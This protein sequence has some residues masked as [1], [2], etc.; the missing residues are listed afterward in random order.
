MKQIAIVLLLLAV[1][2]R[3]AR[4]QTD[5]IAL[6]LSA[7]TGDYGTKD[8][9][10]FA[11][12]LR[13]GQLY[14]NTE[15]YGKIKMVN[16]KGNRF[17]LE[18]VKPEAFFEFNADNTGKV[19]S[20]V[21]KQ[22]GKFTWIKQ[23]DSSG[24]VSAN[25]KFAALTGTYR[26]DIDA[27]NIL[28]VS[29][30]NG[31]LQFAA[32]ELEPVTATAFRRYNEP[33]NN[34]LYEFVKDRSGKISKVILTKDSPEHYVKRDD[35]AALLQ[36]VSNRKNGFTRADTVRGM[37]TPLRTCYDVLFYGLDVTVEPD[38]RSVHGHN[39]IR[40]KTI[41]A[42]DSIQVDL[43]ANMKIDK[44]LFHGKPLS[45]SRKYHAVYVHFPDPLKPG[46]VEELDIY[47]A[48][49]PQLPDIDAMAGGFFWVHNQQGK[50][51]VES[52]CQ[53]AGASLWWPCKD[54]LSDEPDSMSIS[55][56]IPNNG[57]DEISNGRLLKKTALPNNYTRYDW[58]V[59]YPI[60]NYNVVVNIGDFMHFTDHYIR[61]NGDTL[62][63][64]YYCMPYNEN[65]AKLI[66]S[67]VKPM[68]QLFEKLFGEY[69]FSRDGFTVMEGFYPM[70]HQ[71]AVSIGYI[72][73]PFD[74]NKMDTTDIIRLMW[75]EVAHEWWGNNIT[76]KDIADMWIH[77]SFASYAELLAFENLKGK[78]AA[79]KYLS[80]QHP[81]NKEPIIGVYDVNHFHMGDMYTKG[82]LLLHTL[83][84]VINN[85]DL[86]FSILYGLQQDFRYQTVTT[87]DI[88][89]YINKKAKKDYTPFFDQ[90]LRY[91]AIPEL[92]LKFEKKD[93]GLV[94]QYRWQADVVAFDM[95]V[96]I[97]TTPGNMQF[98]YPTTQWQTINLAG[99][100]EKDVVADT[101]NFYIRV[102]TL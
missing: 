30:K 50:M 25:S 53:G 35:D 9:T 102:K 77:E 15:H 38:T 75:H 16:R 76:D 51:W 52:V 23:P 3:T 74:S 31:R 89:T 67:N 56:T 60:N 1:F 29:E 11:I 81:D 91:A 10:Q 100:N 21:I 54:H 58:Y 28:Q 46:N 59:S 47:Y 88:V 82:I 57:L 22:K 97:A 85:D 4:S 95:P 101:A 62:A 2:T 14:F 96:K 26:Q 55:I 79:R 70:E 63:L 36:H 33:A 45:Y 90:Y 39:I 24:S 6:P 94:V 8:S 66:F 43:Y 34:S 27:F 7:Y 98:I 18:H 78:E 92:Q 86:W 72:N 68:L 99:I 84:N 83:R 40:F 49:K 37:L 17:Q 61:S 65:N 87:E 42:A 41:A 12:L 44:I 5:T 13:D 32:T 64:N 80:A 48:G 19:T 73:S 20:L 71:S 69:P 93:Q